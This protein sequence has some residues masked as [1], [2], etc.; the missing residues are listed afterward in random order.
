MTDLGRANHNL[1]SDEDGDHIVHVIDLNACN[2]W[3][4]KWH[5]GNFSEWAGMA[6]PCQYGPQESLTGIQ[7]IFLFWVLITPYKDWKV[8]LERAH[9]SKVRSGSLKYI[10]FIDETN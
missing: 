9:F 10:H 4:K 1:K 6:V 2:L 5:F 3:G 7:K 8:K